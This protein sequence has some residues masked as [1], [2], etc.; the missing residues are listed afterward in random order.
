MA[1]LQDKD[2][3][4][5][6]SLAYLKAQITSDD[7]ELRDVLRIIRP[8]RCPTPTPTL[9][10]SYSGKAAAQEEAQRSLQHYEQR[11]LLLPVDKVWRGSLFARAWAQSTDKQGT[12]HHH[13]MH[14]KSTTPRSARANA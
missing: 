4:S 12:W 13:H 1:A 2:P 5:P 3:S 9:R 10:S 11:A 8:Q 7:K 6:S 14:P